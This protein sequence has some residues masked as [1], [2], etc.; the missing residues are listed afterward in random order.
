MGYLFFFRQ[1]RWGIIVLGVKEQKQFIIEGLTKEQHTI[2]K[3]FW[4]QANNLDCI[5]ETFFVDKDLYEG[6][7][8]GKRL[9]LIYVPGQ[10]AHN[11]LS[12]EPKSFGGHTF[13]RNHEG[14]YKCTDGSQ[15]H[16]CRFR[17]KPSTRFKN[18]VQLFY[19]RYWTKRH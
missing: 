2:Q 16:D 15:T 1:Y 9:L 6:S 5:N 12:T 7:Y 4:N 8:K 13:K 10:V 19:G 18:S 14:D 11:V 3:D 17:R